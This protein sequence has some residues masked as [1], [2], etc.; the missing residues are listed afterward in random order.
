MK[1]YAPISKSVKAA[2]LY[3][4]LGI[5]PSLVAVFTLPIY[6]QHLSVADYGALSLLL[7]YGN[8][9]GMV[10]SLQ[11]NAGA[12]VTY[13]DHAR[14]PSILNQFKTTIFSAAV[15]ISGFNFLLF[16]LIGHLFFDEFLSNSE[17][18]FHREGLMVMGSAVF[19]QLLSIYLLYQRNAYKLRK[20]LSTSVA[21]LFLTVA[22]QYYLI[23]EKQMGITGSV[24]GSLI[25]SAMIVLF[26]VFYDYKLLNIRINKTMLTLTL[27]LAIPLIPLVFLEWFFSA[28]VRLF[29]EKLMTLEDVGKVSLLV[30][31]ML[32]ANKFF[33]SIWS[34]FSPE[35]LGLLK[36]KDTSSLSRI[37]QLTWTYV[38]FG[39]L[40]LSGTLMIGC[41][42]SFLTQN[43]K[44]LEVIPLVPL[45][46]LALLPKMLTSIPTVKLMS[47]KKSK[48]ISLIM[49]IST[50]VL[51]IG[52][53]STIPLFG[54]RG[55]L[56]S[57]LIAN[58]LNLLIRSWK[59]WQF[60]KAVLFTRSRLALIF[61][62][63]LAVV[64][65]LQ[66]SFILNLSYG[67]FGLSQ[68]ILVLIYLGYISRTELFDAGCRIKSAVR[69]IWINSF[70]K[71]P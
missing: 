29:V 50:I 14:D 57:F 2:G 20:F 22:I 4:V 43:P 26:V 34:G 48:I 21:S 36:N 54:L 12:S 27:K 5:L 58:M 56:F 40:V 45:L 67:L 42:L 10:A 62:T 37:R 35:L 41:N 19:N 64:V 68:F 28:G 9:F 24:F 16:S 11:L 25:A 65:I 23:V 51:V 44:F 15:L 59:S 71:T 39:L 30:T 55:I 47:E 17:V 18:L 69:S 33:S 60:S 46:S 3:S 63:S 49:T 1:E 32:V 61:N 8:F 31:I 53:V 38:R 7:F 13:F 52:I 66:V 70:Q 6:L